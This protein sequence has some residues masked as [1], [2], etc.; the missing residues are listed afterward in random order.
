MTQS[1]QKLTLFTGGYTDQGGEGIY[2]LDYCPH[3]LQFG[4]PRLAART[5]HPSFGLQLGK[6]WYWVD[7]APQGQV[8]IY[9]TD[10]P[11]ELTAIQ[12]LSAAGASPC[13][14]AARPDSLY[15]ACSNYM[16]GNI[17]IWRLD[18]TGLPQ[19]EPQQLQHQGRGPSSR[20]AGPHAHWAGWV[21]EATGGFALYAVDLG[22]DAIY[23]YKQDTNGDF[24]PAQVAWAAAPGDGPRHI[25]HPHKPWVYVINELSNSLVFT[26]RHADGHLEEQQRLS[27]LPADF[28]GE[29]I[30]AHIAISRDGQYLYTSNR[31]HHSLAVFKIHS[32]GTLELLQIIDSQG[33]WPRFFVVLDDAQQI[34]VA[35]Q[36]SNNLVV[37][38][39]E[40]DGTLRHTGVSH[41]VPRPTF[42]GLQNN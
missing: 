10:S 13:H 30:A 29:S 23:Y 6:L 31:G 9:Q 4:E 22:T 16:S 37:L 19:G 26:Q 7:E 2:C 15:L 21:I 38:A 39:I 27:T 36:D 35:H 20:Q 34:V 3:T 17:V 24:A 14:L 42:I 11:T 18:E 32:N 1:Q 25:V 28:S 41:T 40:T 8:L 33:A 5:H 12:Q